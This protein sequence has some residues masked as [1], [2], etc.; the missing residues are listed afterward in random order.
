MTLPVAVIPVPAPPA[1]QHWYDLSQAVVDWA[2]VIG[3][4]LGLVAIMVALYALWAQGRDAIRERRAQ[5]ELEVLRDLVP[6]VVE[7]P[8]GY[9]EANALVRMLPPDEVRLVRITADRC[10]KL[11]DYLIETQTHRDET[12][13][14][15]NTWVEQRERM[16]REVIAAIESRVRR[17]KRRPFQ[18][19]EAPQ[20]A[21]DRVT[22]SAAENGVPFPDEINWQSGSDNAT[23]Q[24]RGSNSEDGEPRARN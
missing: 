11:L 12:W 7:K 8:D 16:E 17:K 5:H 20:K 10:M 19:P 24:E 4:F 15:A 3:A 13:L 1:E 18:K 9:R 14:A 2:Q 22:T 23:A 21:E 6:L